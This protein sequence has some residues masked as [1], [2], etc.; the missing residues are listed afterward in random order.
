MVVN[1]QKNRRGARPRTNFG[2][3][4]PDIAS[5]PQARE[6]ALEYRRMAKLGLNP[7]LKARQEVPTFEEVAQHVYSSRLPTRKSAKH[8]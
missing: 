7:R 4:S 1:G 8:N 5:L 3:G 2:L 6:R